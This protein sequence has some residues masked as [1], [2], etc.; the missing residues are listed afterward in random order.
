MKTINL[1]SMTSGERLNY[2]RIKKELTQTKLAV[3]SGI[4]QPNIASYETGNRVLGLNAAKKLAHAL[5]VDYREL[6]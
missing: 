6:I 5:Q 1:N 4:G 3:L 2:Y